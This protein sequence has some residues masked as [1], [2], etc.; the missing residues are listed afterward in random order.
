MA[1]LSAYPQIVQAIEN[2]LVETKLKFLEEVEKYV[3]GKMEDESATVVKEFFDEFRTTFQ[4]EVADAK[5]AATKGAK[6]EKKEKAD[7]KPSEYNIFVGEKI[8][9]IRTQNPG[10]PAKEAMKLAMTLWKEKKASVVA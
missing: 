9:E 8:K 6:K 10:M 1:S 4:K 3:L 5:K 2:T 7:R